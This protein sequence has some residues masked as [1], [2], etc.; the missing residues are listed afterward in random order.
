MLTCINKKQRLAVV[1]SLKDVDND[2]KE[3]TMA[4]LNG[5]QPI[6]RVD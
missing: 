3:L 6:L 4:S 5:L 1:L 2:K